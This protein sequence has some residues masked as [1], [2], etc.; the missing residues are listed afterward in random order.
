MRNSAVLDAGIR[1][2]FRDLLGPSF[3]V[4]SFELR[5]FRVSETAEITAGKEPAKRLFFRESVSLASANSNP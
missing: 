3:K 2:L 5:R 4:L 1:E